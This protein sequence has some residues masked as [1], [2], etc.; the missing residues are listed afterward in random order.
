[1]YNYGTLLLAAQDYPAA[2]Q[3]LEAAVRLDPSYTKAHFN[4][5]A[6]PIMRV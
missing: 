6:A 5:G 3:K 1:M 2:I 4:L